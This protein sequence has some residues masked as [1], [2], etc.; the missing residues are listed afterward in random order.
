MLPFSDED[1]LEPVKNILEEVRPMLK[2]DG[3][4]FEF[5]YIKDGVVYLRLK[6]ACNGC[7]SASKTLK[8]GIEKRLQIE[9]HPELIVKNID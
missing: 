6:G 2:A 5:L 8:Y 3:G 9:I 7:P 4:D 1:L